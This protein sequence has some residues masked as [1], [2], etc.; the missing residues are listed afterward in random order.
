MGWLD[1]VSTK[2]FFFWVNQSISNIS[3]K[4]FF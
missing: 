1:K 4:D 2:F 3:N